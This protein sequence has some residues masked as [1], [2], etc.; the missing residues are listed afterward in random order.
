MNKNTKIIT[1]AAVL[2]LVIGGIYLGAKYGIF[3]KAPAPQTPESREQTQTATSTEQTATTTAK[4]QTKTTKPIQPEEVPYAQ[5]VNL[6]AGRRVQI[7]TNCQLLPAYMVLKNGTNIM[8]DNRTGEATNI[9]IDGK[10][11]RLGAFNY[12]IVYLLKQPLPYTVRIDCGSGKNN[13]QII[14][15]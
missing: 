5:A 14:L 9:W 10:E 11:Y 3:F 7:T 8:I 1:I 6:F 15:Q 4:Q 12:K 2:I 13:G